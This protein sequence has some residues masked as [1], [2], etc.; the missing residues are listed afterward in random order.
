MYIPTSYPVWPQSIPIVLKND[1]QIRK[2]CY[3]LF[4]QTFNQ[5][6]YLEWQIGIVLKV[7]CVLTTLEK[8]SLCDSKQVNSHCHIW[9]SASQKG[10]LSKLWHF[11][12]SCYHWYRTD[13][14]LAKTETQPRSAQVVALI[15]RNE[16]YFFELGKRAQKECLFLDWQNPQP[17]LYKTA[18]VT[19]STQISVT[20]WL[21]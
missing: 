5:Q 3:H 15:D 2:K 10:L 21:S 9:V 12:M 4:H 7:C 1:K 13:L 17:C 18:A 14:I 6:M 19:V 8:M 20:P 11:N 16:I